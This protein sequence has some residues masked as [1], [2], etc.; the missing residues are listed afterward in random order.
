MKRIYKPLSS[1]LTL[2]FLTACGG[3]GGG[4]GG[5][6]GIV[7]PD[8]TPD[9]S[10]PTYTGLT[11]QATITSQNALEMVRGALG[12][13]QSSGGVG[14]VGNQLT[15]SS[16]SVDE[17]VRYDL[18]GNVAKIVK[19]TDYKRSQ[20]SALAAK[21][22]SDSAVSC[23]DGGTYDYTYDTTNA[24]LFTGSFD[25]H[26]CNENEVILNGSVT[27]SGTLN[28]LNEMVTAT[29]QFTWLSSESGAGNFTMGGLF[30]SDY[31]SDPL[32][33][34]SIDA[35][36]R[37][38]TTSNVDKLEGMMVEYTSVNPG[39]DTMKLD[40]RYFNSTHGYVDVSTINT[41]T[42]ADG[43]AWPYYGFF[44]LEGTTSAVSADAQSDAI[45]FT[46][47]LDADGDGLTDIGGTTTEAW[48]P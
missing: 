17:A 19:K 22:E 47:Q 31:S 40:G 16:A 13:T 7:D 23:S 48:Q 14:G 42:I 32:T 44:L 2:L 10:S 28:G 24:P 38:N 46:M 5:D 43:E 45:N 11:T 29:M 36:V 39:D 15:N 4:G 26:D 8:P 41:M 34:M 37:D 27:V 33:R 18:F 12:S 35:R 30:T 6:D 20:Y 25:F 9:T 3:G 21:L 1:A